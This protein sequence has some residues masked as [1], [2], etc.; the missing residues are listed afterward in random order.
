MPDIPSSSSVDPGFDTVDYD[1][2]LHAL[3]D[4]LSSVPGLQVVIERPRSRV[5]RVVGDLPYANDQHRTTDPIR[6]MTITV[7]PVV[8][9]VE[10]TTGR[11]LC[12][13]ETVTVDQGSTSDYH[14]LSEWTDLLV[15]DMARRRHLDPDATAA[16]RSRIRG[17]RADQP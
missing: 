11:P 12:S 7:G 14:E 9:S 4:R 6:R 2:V 3:A 8:Y 17:E 13:V 16:L 15:H 5:S 10:A 1:A